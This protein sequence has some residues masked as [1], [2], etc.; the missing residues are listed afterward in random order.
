MRG[1]IAFPMR[2][3][4]RSRNGYAVNHHPPAKVRVIKFAAIMGTKNQ[5]TGISLFDQRAKLAKYAGFIMTMNGT[6]PEGRLIR[7]L[8]VEKA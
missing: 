3:P 1:V 7:F 6:N 5:I 8:P 2:I 4:E